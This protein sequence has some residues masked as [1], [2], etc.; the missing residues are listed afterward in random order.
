MRWEIILDYT[1]G[2]NIIIGVPKKFKK[3]EKLSWLWPEGD[4]T[5]EERSE[6]YSIAVL[7]I[8][9]SHEPRNVGDL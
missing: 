9:R 4:V 7:K 5:A 2:P 6:T 3:A 8:G 1:D